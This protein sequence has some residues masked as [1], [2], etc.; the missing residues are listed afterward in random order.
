MAEPAIT[1]AGGAFALGAVTL[2]GPILGLEYG[3]LLVGMFGGFVALSRIEPTTRAKMA[4]SVVTSALVAG[5][6]GPVAHAVALEY[7]PWLSKVSE[8]VRWLCAF[9]AGASAQTVVP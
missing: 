4:I 9:V 2:T 1:A 3:T 7:I 6:I 5:Y 8:Q